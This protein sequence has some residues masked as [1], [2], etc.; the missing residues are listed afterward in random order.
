MKGPAIQ[1]RGRTASVNSLSAKDRFW[2]IL[3]LARTPA[4]WRNLPVQGPTRECVL[5]LER[6]HSELTSERS[7]MARFFRTQAYRERP[8]RV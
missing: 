1:L 6:A 4:F 8:L 2:R 3:A 7:V 5:W